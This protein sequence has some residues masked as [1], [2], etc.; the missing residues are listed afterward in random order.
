V[1][2]VPRAPPPCSTRTT[3]TGARQGTH[4]RLPGGAPNYAAGPWDRCF[5]FSA[6]LVWERPS[7]GRSIARARVASSCAFS[8]G[9]RC[10]TKPRSAATGRT[11]GRCSARTHLQGMKQSG[12]KNPVF[13][14]DEVDKLG[15][16]YRGDPSGGLARSPRP[17]TE[18]RLSRSTTWACPT[19]CPRSCSSPPRIWRDTIPSPLRDRMETL[20]LSG[21]QRGRENWRLPRSS[22]CPSRSPR[23]ASASVIFPWGGRALRKIISEYTRE[24]GLRE[25]ERQVAQL[26]AQD[27]A[28]SGGE[29]HRARAGPQGWPYVVTAEEPGQVARTSQ[30]PSPTSASAWTRSGSRTV[31]HGPGRRRSAACRSADDA[32]QGNLILTGQLGEV[33]K[34]SA[35]AALS[36][37][38]GAGHTAGTAQRF[39]WRSR[40]PHSRASR[41]RAQSAAPRLG[42]PWPCVLVSLV[43][44][45]PVRRDVA[46]TARDHLAR[47]GASIGGLKEKL[48]AA[49]RAGMRVAIVPASNLAS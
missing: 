42:S 32:G 39:P 40:D 14:L 31:W 22:W 5:A 4:S 2:C 37:A 18:P 43:S 47:P 26:G 36:F 41:W 46:M 16:D 7:L 44:G 21:Y 15:S 10:A 20:R 27:G 6:H 19:T 8:L 48:L 11:Y 28:A 9:G 1:I 25:L 34:E 45:I 38:A 3:T 49:V 30:V 17:R 12:C 29:R 33:M 24:G 13:M 35:Q 23:P